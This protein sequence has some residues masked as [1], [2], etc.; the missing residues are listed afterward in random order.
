M[1]PSGSSVATAVS[2]VLWKSVRV[3]SSSKVPAVMMCRLRP[4]SSM[5]SSGGR[6][7]RWPALPGM[8]NGYPGLPVPATWLQRA[9]TPY[10]IIA[11]GIILGVLGVVGYLGWEVRWYMHLP[12]LKLVEPASKR[13]TIYNCGAYLASECILW[14]RKGT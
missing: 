5:V 4:P 14:M 6:G 12:D 2:S 13:S 7:G 1:P 10:G 9:L 8:K 3:C 11:A